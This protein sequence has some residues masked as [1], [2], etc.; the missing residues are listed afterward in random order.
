VVGMET[1]NLSDA[2]NRGKGRLTIH[3]TYLDCAGTSRNRPSVSHLR[4]E[5]VSMVR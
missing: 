1:P 2:M 3:W 4:Y 5:G